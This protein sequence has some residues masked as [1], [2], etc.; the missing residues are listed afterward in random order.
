[1]IDPHHCRCQP[2]S[3]APSALFGVVIETI[4]AKGRYTIEVPLHCMGGKGGARA[5]NLRV[6]DNC[7]PDQM[8]P[9][10]TTFDSFGRGG[11]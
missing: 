1:M 10:R 8:G 3:R 2:Q 7:S 9:N 5:L 4:P 11:L 6:L